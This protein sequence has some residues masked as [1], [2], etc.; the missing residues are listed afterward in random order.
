MIIKWLHNWFENRLPLSDSL[1]LRQSNLY[2]V[3]TKAGLA[4]AMTLLLMLIASINYQLNLGYLLTFLLAGSALVCT[5]L[6]F[7]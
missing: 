7:F 2:N 5:V 6:F 1:T 3:P 4:F